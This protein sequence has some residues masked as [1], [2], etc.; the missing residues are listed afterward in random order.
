M[1]SDLT[2]KYHLAQEFTKN[3][4][5]HIHCIIHSYFPDELSYGVIFTCS[6]NIKKVPEQT[7]ISL[8][9]LSE[10]ADKNDAMK[11]LCERA[12]VTGYLDEDGILLSLAE[13]EH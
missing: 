10:E 4:L 11:H 2:M 6:G 7:L 9:S 8:Y 3:G 13:I 1:K 5:Q 12:G